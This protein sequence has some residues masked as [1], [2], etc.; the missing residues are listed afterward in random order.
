MSLNL[1][2]T[3][4]QHDRPGGSLSSLNNRNAAISTFRDKVFVTE[5][6]GGHFC[7]CRTPSMGEVVCTKQSGTYKDEKTMLR[8]SRTSKPT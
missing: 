2:T 4:M 1:R 6:G 3:K 8:S 5:N 7:V